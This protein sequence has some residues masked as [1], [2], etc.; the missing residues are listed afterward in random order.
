MPSVRLSIRLSVCRVWNH[1]GYRLHTEHTHIG[2]RL[3]TEH[4]DP[5]VDMKINNFVTHVP[6]RS[7]IRKI[8]W[9][10]AYIIYAF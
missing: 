6:N 1:I 3:H 10:V 9:Q 4:S 5:K 2:Y 7:F 8:E